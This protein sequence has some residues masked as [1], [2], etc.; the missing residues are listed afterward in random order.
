MLK[1]RRTKVIILIITG[2]LIISV[3][4]VLLF[5]L[6]EKFDEQENYSDDF[7]F[8]LL[9]IILEA[10]NSITGVQN[11]DFDPF[12]VECSTFNNLD[13]EINRKITIS[14]IVLIG[15]SIG[16]Q[17]F[18]LIKNERQRGVQDKGIAS[19]PISLDLSIEESQ[20][21]ALVEEFL[22]Q[23]RVCYKPD[24]V[25]FIK[26]RNF[27]EDN[28]LNHNGIKHILDSLV[29]KHMIVEGSKITRNTT[30]SNLN[31]SSI[32]EEIKNNPGMYL[33]KLSKN[34]GLSIFLTNWHLNILLRFNVIRKQ[35]FNKQIAYFDSELP[36]ENDYI[37]QIISRVKCSELI[38]YLK[39]NSKG[40][41]KSQIAKTL[42]MHHTTV[43]KYLKILIDSQV[44]NLRILDKKN[45]Y[46]L[47][48]EKLNQLKNLH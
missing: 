42:R 5:K 27:Q 38:E 22:N 47:N 24:L 7:N 17:L 43:N 10:S 33:N 15:T 1:G 13:L 30:L 35:E 19:I 31:R 8:N 36:S 29:T 46:R 9:L 37:L 20:I 48:T 14:L 18:D 23:N 45:L 2:L 26:N 21:L 16:A 39:L 3:S 25:S 4:N 32:Y 6:R 34:L 12:N 40:C 28:G 44:V 11:E 41:I